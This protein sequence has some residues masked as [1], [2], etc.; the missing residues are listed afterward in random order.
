MLS[1][2][3]LTAIVILIF[4]VLGFGGGFL[5]SDWRSSAEIAKVNGN[6]TVLSQ[7]NNKCAEDIGNVRI[8][9]TTLEAATNEL[10]RQA[11]KAVQ[12]AAPKVAERTRTIIKIKELPQVAPGQ[13]CE[14]ITKEQID[15]VKARRRE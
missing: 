11:A 12:E 2:P 8:A 3:V 9:M 14:A 7:A 10:E 13:Q 6:N 4:T 1:T 15:Y 5:I